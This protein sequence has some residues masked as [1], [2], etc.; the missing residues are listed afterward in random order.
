MPRRAGDALKEAVLFKKKVRRF[1]EE[2]HPPHEVGRYSVGV[3]SPR[4][5]YELSTEEAAA[6]L[7]CS[8]QYVRRLAK[9]GK[10]RGRRGPGGTWYIDMTSLTEPKAPTE[11]RE[12]QVVGEDAGLQAQVAKLQEENT[13]LRRAVKALARLIES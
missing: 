6:A 4:A 3:E 1:K 12:L 13:Q 8:V 5:G 10:V 11:T 2:P 9:A 7:G